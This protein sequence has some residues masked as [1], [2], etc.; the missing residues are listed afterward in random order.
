MRNLT[1]KLNVCSPVPE[2]V[3]G[4]RNLKKTTAAGVREGD[5]WRRCRG[6]LLELKPPE[7]RGEGGGARRGVGEVRGGRRW[8]N[9]GG[10]AVQRVSPLVRFLAG[11]EERKKGG[12]REG[13][14]RCGPGEAHMGMDGGAVVTG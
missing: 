14:E 13:K 3:D 9:D 6:P 10:G 7:D 4:G 11:E 2:E 8:P 5:P 12:V 1:P